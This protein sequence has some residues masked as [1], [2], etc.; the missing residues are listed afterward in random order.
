[1]TA[2]VAEVHDDGPDRAAQEAHLAQ[3]EERLS[4][5][6]AKLALTAASGWRSY[7]DPE[8]ENY[9][10]CLR[11]RKTIECVNNG[12]QIKAA[13]A[14]RAINRLSTASKAE[15]AEII[16]SYEYLN[17]FELGHARRAEFEQVDGL[18]QAGR[19]FLQEEGT[20]S[21]K[22]FGKI[23][24]A[25]VRKL[26]AQIATIPE[27]RVDKLEGYPKEF[28]NVRRK[29]LAVFDE[30]V[31]ISHYADE[32]VYVTTAFLITCDGDQKKHQL[33]KYKIELN[34]SDVKTFLFQYNS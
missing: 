26:R 29:L 30:V 15:M 19:C 22:I 23:N 24:K 8:F 6:E 20:R 1:V 14:K 5:V 21:T 3:L 10:G 11:D 16:V 31:D 7:R 27:A 25:Q 18:Y 28:F 33:A 2:P 17:N 9:L 4:A 13:N 32:Q 12:G 34:L